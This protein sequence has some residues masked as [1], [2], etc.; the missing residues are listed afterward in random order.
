MLERRMAYQAYYI[1]LKETTE[2]P[3]SPCPGCG[4]ICA[5]ASSI[6]HNALPKPGDPTVCDACG[7]L[8]VFGRDLKLR[9]PDFR[10]LRDLKRSNLWPKLEQLQRLF[11]G[12]I[13]KG[14]FDLRPKRQ[15]S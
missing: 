9:K 7:E 5:S 14:A 2:L 13:A 11:R 10:E 8:L 6:D 1:P 3:E 12:A 4:R 15:P